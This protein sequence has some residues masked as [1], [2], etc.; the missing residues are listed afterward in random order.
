M[1]TNSPCFSVKQSQEAWQVFKMRAAEKATTIKECRQFEEYV[2]SKEVLCQIKTYGQH[3]R[4]NIALALEL[5]RTW[6][7]KMKSTG[8]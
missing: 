6:F 8:E 5:A 4:L 3:Q 2:W 1:K 7:L